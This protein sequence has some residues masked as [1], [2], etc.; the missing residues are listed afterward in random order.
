MQ[1]VR[2]ICC[3][4]TGGLWLSVVQA[5]DGNAAASRTITGVVCLAENAN[6]LCPTNYFSH[7]RAGWFPGNNGS[8]SR[9]Y[10]NARQI[11]YSR[12]NITENIVQLI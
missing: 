5:Q 8:L 9:R 1:R 2:C 10:I 4:I 11:A 3:L 6:G 12:L 7:G